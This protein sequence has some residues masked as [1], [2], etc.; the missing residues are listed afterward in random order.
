MN[1]INNNIY[2]QE[3]LDLLED[4]AFIKDLNGIYLSC[5]KSFCNFLSLEKKDIIGKSDYDLFSTSEADI[6]TSNDKQIIKNSEKKV[7]YESFTHKDSSVLYFKTTKDILYDNNNKKLATI[8]IAKD[9]TKQKEYETLYRTNQKILEK[10][11]EDIPLEEILTY[12]INEVEKINSNMICSILL[13]DKEKKH[14]SSGFAPSLPDFYN[15]AV[16]TITVRE[17]V[18]SC[19]TAAAT[20]KRVIVENI[21]EHPY[22]EGFKEITNSIG[23]HA[24][25]SQPFFSR[26]KEV[27][28]TF[29]IYYNK[30]KAPTKFELELIDS[31]AHLVSIAV[32]KRNRLDKIK[33]QDNLLTH[34]A[35][36]ATL[37]E[38][39]ENIAHQWRQPL[40][41]ISTV[42]S[43]LKLDREYFCEN[44]EH[45][46]KALS[47]IIDT[48]KYL[49]NTINDFRT[50]FLDNKRKERF[51]VTHTL[52]KTLNIIDAKFTH[53][54][55]NY[56]LD[57]D[58][59]NLFT[60]ENE[61]IHIFLNLLNNAKDAFEINNIEDRFIFIKIKKENKHCVIKIKDNAKGIPSEIINKIFEPY[62]TTKHKAQGTGIGLYMAQD[63]L[64]R[65]M[66]ATIKVENCNY[67]YNNINCTG[68]E[69]TIYIPVV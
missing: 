7:F 46:D 51:A 1:T 17:G 9:I 69:F 8:N 21:S 24:C 48:T 38:M 20:Q 34:Q 60:Y 32:N 57:V 22:W 53:S 58:N 62:F 25:W 39:L 10:T 29:A 28:G 6:F 37:G 14:F 45:H 61:L 15:E 5:N 52:D 47:K 19:G 23:V 65:H 41:V 44:E 54:N 35:K 13:L 11:I 30:P 3:I 31:F 16:K 66:D 64:T 42:T 43:N 4:L 26:K 27:L 59:I 49:S 56:I 67:S 55:I 18:G 40:S 50:Y 68:A 63:I 2:S 12:I 36:M 33:E